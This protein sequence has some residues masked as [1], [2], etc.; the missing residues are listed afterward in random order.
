M[1]SD[2]EKLSSLHEKGPMAT[3][4]L[5]EQTAATGSLQSKEPELNGR[6]YVFFDTPFHH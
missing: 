3:S 5:S 1:D 2:K 4:L 6:G